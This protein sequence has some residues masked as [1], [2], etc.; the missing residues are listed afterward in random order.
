MEEMLTRR[1]IV[2][3]AYT[4]HALDHILRAVHEQGVTKDMLR[5]GSRS[6]DEIAGQYSLESL[7]KE[8][9]QT[10][11]HMEK[12]RCA[13]AMHEIQRVSSMRWI[14]LTDSK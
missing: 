10:N 3:L 7:E 11:L 1:P 6:K 2:L 14:Q 13:A 12:G 9:R 8:Q 5:L 4:N